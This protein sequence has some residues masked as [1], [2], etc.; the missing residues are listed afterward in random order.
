LR[1]PRQDKKLP[2]FL[3]ENVLAKLLDAPAQATPMGAR[4][5]AILEALYSA[6]LRVSELTGLN[7]VDVD[8]DAGLANVRGRGRKE[9]L[10][11]LGPEALASLKRWLQVRATLL[12]KKA[13][14]SDKSK[15]AVFLNK[16]GT[17]LTSR[18]VGRMI[19]KYLAQTGLDP[20]TS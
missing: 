18:S 20:R 11:F 14:P 3:G 6:G 2:H 16:N 13:S 12:A 10:A 7:T 9:R 1:G 15:D 8:L 5:K 19:E 4:D 17:R